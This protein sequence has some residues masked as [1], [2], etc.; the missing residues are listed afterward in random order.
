MNRIGAQPFAPLGGQAEDAARL[1]AAGRLERA[2]AC[3]ERS[4]GRVIRVHESATVL[5]ENRDG[6]SL[7]ERL[8]VEV[9]AASPLEVLQARRLE[10]VGSL[11]TAMAPDIDRLAADVERRVRDLRHRFGHDQAAAGE[12]AACA[13]A[14]AQSAALVRQLAAFGRRQVGTVATVNLNDTIRQ[15]EPMLAQLVGEYI[16]FDIRLGPA[17]TLAA[18]TQDLDQLLT[19]LVT[20]G[21]DALPAGGSL[22]LET[23]TVAQEEAVAAELGPSTRVSLTA[24]GYGVQ[25][26][27]DAPALAL[28]ARRAG[29]ELR[30]S[31]E[32]GWQ[33]QLHAIFPRC[34]KR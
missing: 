17:A 1:A 26:A 10:E 9:D 4:D 19:S 6:E 18:N 13:S 16:G 22:L 20:F 29:A 31:G 5:P 23:S 25:H 27:V 7:V 28:V 2:G 14:A 33:L 30:V 3:L 21:R 12:I 15:A 11:T 8:V 32:P 24:S 34:A